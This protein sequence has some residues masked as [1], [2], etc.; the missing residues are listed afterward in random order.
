MKKIIS[1]LLTAALFAAL[2]LP[3]LA[4]EPEGHSQMDVAG[5]PSGLVMTADGS[6]LVTDVYN[7][8]VWKVSRGESTRYAGQEGVLDKDGEP[9]GGY[10]DAALEESFF[11][12]PWAI[13]PFLDGWA[14]SDAANNVL[15]LIR[16][17]GVETINASS[18]DS[19]LTS[20][21]MG[22]AYDRPTGLAVDAS[23]NLYVSNTGTGDII[24]ISNR[25]YATVYC[26]GL[27]APTGL[28]WFN[29]AL[30]VAETGANRVVKIVMNKP[31]VVAGSGEQGSEDGPAA[32]AS[33]SAPTGVAVGPDGTVYVADTANAAVRRVRD[34]RVDTILAPV[35]GELS[36]APV[37]PR[38]LLLRGDELLVCDSYARTLIS[39]PLD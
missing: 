16:E 36:H 29:H 7:K 22:V 27:D 8:C 32:S 14:V 1:L 28:C 31:Q 2:G 21:S 4:A 23:G 11:K 18:H 5:A 12:E 10:K 17:K 3:A 13:A 38:G 6:L 30:Y 37:S 26:S 15:R 34:G 35:D 33:F 19:R 24:C 25:G 9:I 39:L 20:G